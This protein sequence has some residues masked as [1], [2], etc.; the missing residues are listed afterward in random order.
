[1]TDR[2]GDIYD[3]LAWPRRPGVDLL[4]RAAHNRRVEHPEKHLW[5]AVRSTGPVGT[6]NVEVPRG[7]HRAPRRAKLTVRVSE[8]AVHPPRYRKHEPGLAEVDVSGALA[9]EENPPPGQEAILWLLVTTLSLTG[10]EEA[11]RCVEHYARRWLVERYHYVL[12]RGGRV[13]ELQR[14]TAD[15]LERVLALYSIVAWRLLWLTCEARV[16]PP[17]PCTKVL[18][19]EEWPALYSMVHPKRRLPRRPPSLKDAISWIGKLGGF[20]GRGGDRG[21]GVKTLWRGVF[22]PHDFTAAL[23]TLQNS[24]SGVMGNA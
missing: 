19:R 15:R 3:L 13:E 22:R 24:G 21:R 5:E 1:M 9:E 6:M 10:K 18:A 7:A 16:H 12:K 4:V 20:L 2:E 11:Q 23:K 14:E 17:D 8:V